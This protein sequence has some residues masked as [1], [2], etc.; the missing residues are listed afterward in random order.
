MA[1]KTAYRFPGARPYP[2]KNFDYVMSGNVNNLVSGDDAYILN[3]Y[4][5]AARTITGILEPQVT[6]GIYV[7]K[8]IRNKGAYTVTLS[9]Q[10]A[11]SDADNRITVLAGSNYSLTAGSEVLLFYDGATA[12]WTDATPL[13]VTAA[14]GF[15]ASVTT[16]GTFILLPGRSKWTISHPGQG[17]GGA[18][19]G[20]VAYIQGLTLPAIAWT[21]ADAQNQ[22][23]QQ[24]VNGASREVEIRP[25]MANG[26]F[27]IASAAAVTVQFAP[28][29]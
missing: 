10:S 4:P 15:K 13:P 12:E 11:S 21:V 23:S 29:D 17:A 28:R 9:H 26:L 22:A 20:T 18:S 8:L 5:D 1:L 27:M 7:V 3:L 16:D 25:G 6:A 24:L 14:A 2:E 19:T